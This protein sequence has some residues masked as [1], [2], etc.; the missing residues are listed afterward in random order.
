M[1]VYEQRSDV[2]RNL[3]TALTIVLA[4]LVIGQVWFAID[5][6]PGAV[7]R[8]IRAADEPFV[9]AWALLLAAGVTGVFF[10]SRFLIRSALPDVKRGT[11]AATLGGASPLCL[12]AGV[13]TGM[14]AEG[15]AVAVL[16]AVAARWF[17]PKQDAG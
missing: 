6:Q 10:L 8:S 14:L 2:R 13:L 1:N 17:T 5:P 16:L 9:S 12:V 11:L 4:S 3:K 7:T 15:A